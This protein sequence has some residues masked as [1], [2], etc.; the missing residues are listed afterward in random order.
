M[1]REALYSRSS[2]SQ[3]AGRPAPTSP[4]DHGVAPAPD[5]AGQPRDNPP[6]EAQNRSSLRSRLKLLKRYERPILLAAGG[7]FALLL[8]WLHGAMQPPAREVTQRDIDAAVLHTLE[9]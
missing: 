7:L 1:R 5:S 2:R 8:V 6:A 3:P 9:T 4:S